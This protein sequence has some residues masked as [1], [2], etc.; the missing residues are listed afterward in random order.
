MF[1]PLVPEPDRPHSPNF[2]WSAVDESAPARAVGNPFLNLG[3][4][5]EILIESYTGSQ[6]IV[7]AETQGKIVVTT[8][9]GGGEAIPAGVHRIAQ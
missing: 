7:E 5:K 1:A 2:G 8:E 4:P 6:N 3:S 9:L